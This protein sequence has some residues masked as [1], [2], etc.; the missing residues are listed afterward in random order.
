MKLVAAIRVLVDGGANRWFQ[1]T[2][3]NK[4]NGLE[5]PHFLTGDMDSISNESEE[6]LQAMNCE[7][8][9]TPDQNHTDC[10]KA[11]MVI[12]PLLE[13]KQVHVLKTLLFARQY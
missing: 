7:R 6:R 3:Q 10:T 4:L 12:E 11:L 9:E 2:D 13:R 8:I 1:Y 5:K